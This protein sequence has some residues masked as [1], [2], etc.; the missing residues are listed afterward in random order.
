M[1]KK[2]IE[3]P[4]P[5]TMFV[6]GCMIPPGEGREV[7]THEPIEAEATAQSQ[8][9][10]LDELVLAELAKPVKDVI[11]GLSE[12]THEG[13]DRMEALESESKKRKSLLEAIAAEKVARADAAMRLAELDKALGEILAQ[14]AAEIVAGLQAA[15]DEELARLQVLEAAAEQ[16]RAEVLEAIAAEIAKRAGETQ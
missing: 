1:A 2:Y 6:G 14:P 8:A 3:N 16:P 15:D 10:S 13:L 7:E 5:N 11:A 4:G 12:L 9:P